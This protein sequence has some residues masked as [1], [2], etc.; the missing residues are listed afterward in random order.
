MFVLCIPKV[1]LPRMGINWKYS[2][3]PQEVNASDILI[4]VAH[5]ENLCV[6]DGWV[7]IVLNQ[8]LPI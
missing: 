1:P 6:E 7:H 8:I 5:F 3:K 2:K 4:I